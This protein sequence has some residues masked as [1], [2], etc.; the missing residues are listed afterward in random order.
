MRK[1]T[2]PMV[3]NLSD[4]EVSSGSCNSGAPEFSVHPCNTFGSTAL[5]PCS[6]GATQLRRDI[7]TPGG[8]AG[9]SCISGTT[10]G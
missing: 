8:D 3:R 10:A 7:C 9:F 1:Y 5:P 2:K 4:L 6:T